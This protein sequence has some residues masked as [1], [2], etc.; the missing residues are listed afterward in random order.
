MKANLQIGRLAGIP[1]Q[2]HWSF[3][4]VI[5]WILFSSWQPGQGLNG[6]TLRWL[7]GWVSLVFLAVI[8]H[9]L[10]HALMA[11]RLGINTQKI[12]I[13]P[14][15]GGAFL[16]R[17]PEKARSE[18]W[19]A[20]AGPLVNL[21]LAIACIP[22]IWGPWSGQRPDILRLILNPGSNT[23]LYDT[24]WWEYGIVVFFLLN[25]LLAIFNLLPAYPL[26]GGRILRAALSKRMPRRKAT[27]IAA[28]LGVAFAAAFLVVAYQ[29]EDWFFATGAILVGLLAFAEFQM[30]N[31]KERL[32]QAFVKDYYTSDFHRLYLDENLT[33]A[34]VRSQI[35]DWS[36]DAILLIDQWQ[37]P[38]AVTTAQA[39]KA[40]A[41]DAFAQSNFVEVLGPPNWTGLLPEENLLRAAEKLDA[42][43]LYAFPVMDHHGRI[44]GLLDRDT[45]AGVMGRK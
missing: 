37:Q 41:M 45:I 39:I 27:L 24:A 32:A 2:F 9:E 35:A 8:L 3:L 12:V 36:E 7:G 23:V 5:G 1:L 43:N 28:G 38:Y 20:F 22:F 31:R 30:Q 13:Y 19:I 21:V 33:V 25:A 6:F 40:P 15:G 44:L 17:L 14:L 34:D 11:R 29:T 16:E 4:L 10:G 26:D 42:D 18:I